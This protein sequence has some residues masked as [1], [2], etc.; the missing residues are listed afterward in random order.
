MIN[1]AAINARLSNIG[2]G[3]HRTNQ[4]PVLVYHP[5]EY[6]VQSPLFPG[7]LI[8]NYGTIYEIKRN[9][10][11]STYMNSKGYLS[12]SIYHNGKYRVMPI[13]RVVMIAHAFRPDYENLEVNHKNKCTWFNYYNPYDPEHSNLEWSTGLENIHHAMTVGVGE[14]HGFYGFDT[15]SDEQIETICKMKSE[16]CSYQE[17][18]KATGITNREKLYKIVRGLK[19]GHYRKDIVSKYPNFPKSKPTFNHTEEEVIKIC[20]MLQNGVRQVDIIRILRSQGFP[21]NET[22]VSDIAI[23][24]KRAK[25]WEYIY[26]NYNFK[27]HLDYD[28][29]DNT[30]R[31]ICELVRD[32]HTYIDTAVILE[33][34]IAKYKNIEFFIL[35]LRHN[36]IKY[37]RHITTQYFPEG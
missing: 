4:Y 8:G 6:F 24:Y 25:K 31:K 13:H 18:E 12:V 33:I 19:T 30:I 21:T 7:Y 37:Y 22:F 20:E 1:I 28:F 17:I 27:P 14:N 9:I 32:G 34:D 23:H 5:Y 10:I 15:Y 35:R 3:A 26:K 2:Y 36:R 11:L 16:G 29:D